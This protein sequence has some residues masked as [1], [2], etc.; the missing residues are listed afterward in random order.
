MVVS[1]LCPPAPRGKPGAARRCGM[2]GAG[3]RSGRDR[4]DE[5][6]ALVGHARDAARVLAA[7]DHFV[8][9]R[10][11]GDHRVAVFLLVDGDIGDHRPVRGDHGADHVVQFVGRPGAQPDHAVGLG[12]LHEI[13]QRGR[14]ALRVAAA[15]QQFLP[16]PHH[17]HVLVV[18][19][20]QL[21]RQP[22]LRQRAELLDVHQDA[23]LAGDIDH[24]VLG[25][26]DLHA[27]G[28]GQA[29]AHGA[30]AAAGH[31]A[32]RPVELEEL[33]GPHL[34]LADL[35]GDVGLAPGPHRGFAG[36]FIQALHR[37][38]RLDD[39][40]ALVGLVEAQAI[41]APPRIDLPPPAG[42]RGAVGLRRVGV[43][44]RKQRGQSA[45]GV[46]NDGDLDG[47]VLV[48]RGRVDVDVDLLRMRAEGVQPPGH[49]V[50]EARADRQHDIA[51][52]HG[53]VG[54]IGAVHAQHAQELR[55]GGREGAESHQRAGAGEA[56][57]A[58]E[59]RQR[60]GGAR[61]GIDH[62][63]AGVDH[64]PLGCLQHRHGAGD[65][66]L[67]RLGLRPVGAV[68]RLGRALVRGLA[69]QDVLRQVDH[70]RAGPAAA[71]DVERL[72]DG[73]G[74]VARTLD[75]IIVLG[76]GAGDAGGVGFLEGVVADQVRRHLAGEADDGNAVQQRIHQ[77]GHRIGGARAAGHQHHAHLAG[78]AGI[79]LGGVH[80]RLFM[81][82]Q[83]VADGVL[84]EQRIVDRQDRSAGVTEYDL[85]TLIL[86]RTQENLGAWGGVGGGGGDLGGVCVGHGAHP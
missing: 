25:M 15:V 7:Q 16:L 50:V 34:V 47:N 79:A 14:V 4:S 8:M 39:G 58:H 52:M 3:R 78:G 73:A 28:G 80:G 33:G 83:D 36:Q 30:Q 66:G 62:A 54:F 56:G 40:A 55:I 11:R 76:G 49:P 64:R 41:E 85:Y 63:A 53:E 75:Q 68:R 2:R 61:A 22:V 24:Q 5:D 26:G 57:L 10:A 1:L 31:P 82:H 72:V 27:H 69:D 67:V 84:L 29:V 60:L 43:P 48:D 59:L 37:V 23:G 81:A 19:D 86:E 46:G 77:S 32:V 17:A 20:E 13:G 44:G 65:L 35:G 6:L 12:E 70:H 45:A 42:D 71:G 18:Q 74:E 38:L 21:H 9:G 51:A